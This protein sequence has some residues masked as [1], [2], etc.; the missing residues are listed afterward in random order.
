MILSDYYRQ[1]QLT[2]L[3]LL[4][5]C[6]AWAQNVV[7][8][9]SASA[10]KIGMQDQL[11]VTYTIQD[12]TNLQ[13]LTP[14]GLNKDFEI[15]AGPF[16]SQSSQVSY[17]N[18][19]TTQTVNVTLTYV[20]VPKHTGNLT[21]PSAIAKDAEGHSYQSNAI[22]V[23]V[24]A[25]SLAQR[26]QA[27]QQRQRDVFDED[28]FVAMMQQRQ[29]QL[30]AMRQQQYQ[31]QQQQRAQPQAAPQQ[32][33]AVSATTSKENLGKDL[34][35]RV[36]VDKNKVHVGE[37]ITATYKLYSRVPMNVAIAKL[38]TLNGFWTQDFEMAKPNIKPAEEIVDGKKYQVF[39]LKKSAL[40]PQQTGTLELDPAE[41]EGIARIVQTVKHRNPF[42]DDPV[43]G[44]LMMNDPFFNDDMFNSVSYRD[45]KVN[46][47]STP[48]KIEVSALPADG[49]PDDYGGAVGKFTIDGKIDKTDITTD[50]AINYKLTITGSGN[51]KLIEAPELK[52]PN[53]L[54]VFE[55]NIIDTIT[56]RTTTISG[57][58][59]I[60]YAISA[61]TPGDFQIPGVS[62]TYFDAQAG[63][64]VT[65]QTQPTKI[66][67]KPGKN[68]KPGTIAKNVALTDIHDI[69]TKPLNNLTYN[70]KPLLYTVGYW[71]MY[72]LP[73]FA[74]IALA[75]WRRR[76]DELSKDSILLK[77]KRAN[78]VALKRLTA[79]RKLLE[80]NKPRLFYDEVSKAI[81][82]YLSDKLSIP[83][84]SLSRDTASIALSS[85]NLPPALRDDITQ[86]ID[87]CE[88][89]LYS[90]AGGAKLMPHVYHQAIEVIS[91][92]EDFF[93]TK[94]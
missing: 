61:Q 86:L 34:F 17:A 89:A 63:N 50:D 78:K 27:Q 14:Q 21:V 73:L 76:E 16:Q 47:K 31:Q 71:S 5:G 54:E 43:F 77:S 79:A 26:Q 88:V 15:V 60:T 28:P 90:P 72:S 48:V 7:F 45:V 57:S 6:S 20:L 33:A 13:S 9:A 65:L 64:Y 66:H 74:F 69:D 85:K 75:V 24:V 52:L 53:G 11:Q 87:E 83:L 18:G 23:Q 25:G 4:S 36:N 30:Q 29:R 10:G 37:Q 70:S 40:F 12:A 22:P 93:N 51:L 42:A 3:F 32:Q 56:G 2:C 38:P 58:K 81:W 59:I 46:L 94:A 92:L 44:S 1:I 68:Y 80:E 39:T 19:R 41:A 84:S 91:K 62:F 67:V 8:S 82:L 35:I 49:K 55:P